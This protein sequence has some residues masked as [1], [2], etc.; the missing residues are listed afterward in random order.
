VAPGRRR[1]HRRR[2]Y[3]APPHV[4]GDVRPDQFPGQVLTAEAGRPCRV[5]ILLSTHRLEMR[6]ALSGAAG[7]WS[8]DGVL[9]FMVSTRGRLRDDRNALLRHGPTQ[10][11]GRPLQ[12]Q[13]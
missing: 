3:N 10:L 1:G 13:S 2:L 6:L 11:A 7:G 12:A 4:L 8:T 5:L 9:F